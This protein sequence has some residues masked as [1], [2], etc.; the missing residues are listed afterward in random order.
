MVFEQGR[1]CNERGDFAFSESSLGKE[2]VMLICA[3][4]VLV[5]NFC[6]VYFAKWFEDSKN[7]CLINIT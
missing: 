4:L 1:T 3:F 2:E 5:F 6:K 7:I